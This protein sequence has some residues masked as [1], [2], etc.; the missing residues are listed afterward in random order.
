MQQITS[1]NQS[2]GRATLADIEESK[3]REVA[4]AGMGMSDLLAFWFGEPDQVTPEFIRDAAKHALDTGATFYTQN[5]GI[6]PLREAIAKYVSALHRPTDSSRIAVTSSGVS[7]LML[8]YQALFDPGDRVVIITPVWPNVTEGPK[9]LGAAVTRV[10]LHYEH[11]WKLDLSRLLAALTPQTRAVII[12]SPNNPTGWTMDRD[13]QEI[14]LAHCRKHGIWIIADDVY[15]R[16]YFESN[17][18]CAPSFLDLAHQD[19]LVVSTN[20]FSKSWLMTGWRLG[21]IVA[22]PLL[23]EEFAKLIEYNT[24]CA[25]SFVQQAGIVALEQGESVT[26]EFL[27]RLKKARDFLVGKLSAVPGVR[28]AAPPGAMYLFLGVEGVV[29]SVSFAKQLVRE[30]KLGLAP[31]VAFGVEGEGYLRWCFASSI[32]RL[33][34]GIGRFQKGL[35]ALRK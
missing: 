35:A 6:P 10:P 5:L 2:G 17:A 3:I 16:L 23:T 11:G 32:E 34:D 1:Q 25:P 18:T 26:R 33:E 30:Q 12:N 29:D 7:A 24:S 31:G 9:I 20:S 8:V 19:D 28:V 4:N 14:V 27:Q 13:A 21:W 22:P 15:E